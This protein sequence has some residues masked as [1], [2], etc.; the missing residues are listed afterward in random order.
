MAQQTQAAQVQVQVRTSVMPLQ[1]HISSS[2]H[3]T[4][5]VQLD[6]ELAW[7]AALAPAATARWSW[8]WR[9]S[10]RG[11]ARTLYTEAS[12]ALALLALGLMQGHRAMRAPAAQRVV[13]ASV[14]A[15]CR[16]ASWGR[17]ARL[18]TLLARC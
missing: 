6:P 4:P 13:P 18:A 9:A 1:L 15:Q 16:Y 14:Q 8:R 2:C 11:G 5:A 3:Y 17:T 7:A 12:T 10:A